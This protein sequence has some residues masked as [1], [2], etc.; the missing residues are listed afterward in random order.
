MFTDKRALIYEQR[1][2]GIPILQRQFTF[3]TPYASPLGPPKWMVW[4][5]GVRS[6]ISPWAIS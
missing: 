3:A 1:I 4:S 5:D 6:S 2:R